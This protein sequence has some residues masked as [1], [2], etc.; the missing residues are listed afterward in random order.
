[1]HVSSRPFPSLQAVEYEHSSTEHF[2]QRMGAASQDAV[3]AGAWAEMEEFGVG[4]VCVLR[5]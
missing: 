2:P 4:A 3:G 1:M 5:S